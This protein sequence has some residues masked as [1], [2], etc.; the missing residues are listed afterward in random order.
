M[1][2]PTRKKELDRAAMAEPEDHH[3]TPSTIDRLKRE[4][5]DLETRQRP[6]GVSEVRRLAEMGDFSENAGYQIAKATLRRINNRIETLKERIKT[7]VPIASGP[8]TEGRARIGSTVVLEKNGQRLTFEILGSQ[9]TSP[10]RGR[11]SYHSPLG[12]ALIGCQVGDV[13]TV[14][15]ATYR[16]LKIH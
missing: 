1:R 15:N 12:A 7:A 10:S 16:L 2:L 9:E 4:L 11:I 14:T 8:D 5:V 3:L 13:V 6:E